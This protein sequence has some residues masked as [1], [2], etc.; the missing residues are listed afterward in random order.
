MP[1]TTL[2][3]TKL[4]RSRYCDTCLQITHHDADGTS[5]VL[6]GRAT[7]HALGSDVVGRQFPGPWLPHFND[8]LLY[9]G[10][11][12]L[13]MQCSPQSFLSFSLFVV[14]VCTN[15]TT[16]VYARKVGVQ[17]C[18]LLHSQTRTLHQ[19]LSLHTHTHTHIHS[20]SLVLVVM[21][22]SK[23]LKIK[24]SHTNSLIH[25]LQSTREK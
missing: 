22:Q 5:A 20:S 7:K 17:C 12:L 24:I 11:L 6:M 16:Y 10:P 8:S 1:R 21:M 14:Y 25:S 18:T 19:S 13:A 15:I 2:K 23:E 4:A 3:R 9:Q